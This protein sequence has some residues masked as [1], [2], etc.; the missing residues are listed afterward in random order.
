MKA[1]LPPIRNPKSASRN[2]AS[3]L[4]RTVSLN[5]TRRALGETNTTK[6]SE[7]TMSTHK[8]LSIELSDGLPTAARETLAVGVFSDGERLRAQE[9]LGGSLRA[10]CERVV[11]DGE[12]EGE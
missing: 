7:L 8:S 4:G 3:R 6:E 9:A 12:F 11:S 1:S 10:L 2:P 5:Y